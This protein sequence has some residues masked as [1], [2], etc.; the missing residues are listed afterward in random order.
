MNR[1]KIAIGGLSFA[2]ATSALAASAMAA[3]K[4][5]W[6][7]SAWG[8]PRAATVCVDVLS[9]YVEEK[10][11]GNFTIKVHYGETISPAKENL[12]GLKIG[13]FEI[14]NICSGYHPG[15]NLALTV[16]DLPFLPIT[17][18]EQQAKVSEAFYQ[19]AP[20]KEEAARWNA[21]ITFRNLLPQSE[22]LGRGKPPTTLEGWKGMRVR[23]LG[24]TGQAMEKI[25]AIPT[26]V[27]AP[28]V[29][30]GIE[31]GMFDA[32]AFPFSYAHGSYR[33]HEV[34]DWYTFNMAPGVNHC[35][36]LH[37]IAAFEALPAEYRQL[38]EEAKAISYEKS[39]EAFKAA[40]E[41]WIPLFDQNGLERILYSD[42]VLAAFR[43]IAA[44][45]VWE[46]WV[47]D[48]TARG[49]PGQE[50]LDFVMAEAKKSAGS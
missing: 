28:E 50:L 30:T 47:Q 3:E 9:Q 6:N 34:S 36:T 43:E 39:I 29:Y 14:G 44:K 15:K 12:D 35:L 16:L 32:V 42:E 37:N 7:L 2:L 21:A 45:P 13:A 40:D 17:S 41:K 31:R 4:I 27:P 24:G 10:S 38:I 33:V 26:S 23:A 19:L 46:E 25:G 49:V 18:L 11:G 8:N 20:V 48:V 1:S 22:F 5:E